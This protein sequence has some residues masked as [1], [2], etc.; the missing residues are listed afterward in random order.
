MES[1]KRYEKTLVAILF[2]TWGTVFLD[3]MSQMY[4]A[5]YFAPEFHLSSQQIGLLAS[6][7]AVS[8]A[9]SALVFG[10]IS[11]HS[12]RRRILIPAVFIFSSMSWLSGLAHTFGQ[13]LAIRAAMGLA[14]GPCWAVISALNEESSH[15]SRRGRNVGLVVSAGALVGLAAAPV[16]TTQIASRIGWRWGFFLSGVPGF[17]MGLLIWKY[18]KEPE[19][20]AQSANA[21]QSML[22]DSLSILRYRN[23]WLCSAG[24]VG[25]MAWLYLQN[26][27]APLYITEVAHQPATTA[28]FLLG[29]AGLGSFFT[30]FLFPAL[31][32]RLGRRST[33]VILAILSSLLPLALLAKPLY[34][35]PWALAAILFCTQTG[36][37][38][39]ALIIVLVPA[40]SVPPQYSGTAIGLATFVGEIIGATVAP[41]LGGTLAEKYGLAVPLLMAAGGSLLLF[42]ASLFLEE[43]SH[44]AREEA[45]VPVG[46]AE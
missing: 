23:V 7:L 46:M 24:A 5:P 25:F 43:P 29:A 40:E 2:F 26:V 11:D 41:T 45:P 38:V 17:L 27:F 6:V 21:G 33:L 36:Q 18:V 19:R 1:S 22:R 8:W 3:R 37:A 14:D 10:A 9:L 42:L 4:L 31:S 34:A 12:G 13:L 16:L 15:P 35:H 20:R 32:D 44:R 30:G 28:G 39:A